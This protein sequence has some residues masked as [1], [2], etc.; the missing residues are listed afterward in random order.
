MRTVPDALATV[1][2]SFRFNYG[3]AILDAYSLGGAMPDTS[4]TA[5]A[6]A[7]V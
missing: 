2:T 4:G 5:G 3:T 7:L 6:F 1:D